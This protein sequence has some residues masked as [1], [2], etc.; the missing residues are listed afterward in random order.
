QTTI[1]V[2]ACQIADNGD[3]DGIPNVLVE[4]M[5]MGLP[6][7]STNISGL[8]EL[9]DHTVNGLLV[10]QKDA[11]ALADAVAELLEHP[12]LRRQFGLAAREKICRS[13]NAEE[14]IVTLYRLLLSCLDET[15]NG[16]QLP[17]DAERATHL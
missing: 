5:A 17:V 14:N 6:V 7:I 9:I 12:M 4:A 11:E 10:P 8:P 16:S 3:R 1:F 15:E 13:F 2:L